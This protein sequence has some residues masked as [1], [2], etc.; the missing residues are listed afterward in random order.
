MRI[1]VMSDTHMLH[2]L[3]IV[4][5]GDVLV[6]CG[7]WSVEQ[8]LGD[9]DD[10]F[11]WYSDLP[12]R[13]KLLTAGNH[14]S[15]MRDFGKTIRK[16]IPKSITYLQ[17]QGTE[18]DGVRFW[19]SPYSIAPHFHAFTFKHIGDAERH[20]T[21]VLDNI[22]VLITHGPPYGVLDKNV[23]GQRI[24]DAALYK[25]VEKIRPRL[26]LFGH[27]HECGGKRMHRFGTEF[28]NAAV[29]DDDRLPKL[30]SRIQVV[31]VR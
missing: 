8:A 28:I 14:E 11:A 18:I 29:G 10:F 19:A 25:R 24:G 30:S 15:L 31:D 13:N 21:Q 17:D 5:D 3:L 6:H 26:H 9:Y 12:H 23:S 7:D 2:R 27:V 1:V 16:R 20:W 22:D 4:P